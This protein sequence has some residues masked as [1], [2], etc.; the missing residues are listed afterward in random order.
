VREVQGAVK[1]AA[2]EA[3]E[4]RVNCEEVNV[5]QNL[6]LKNVEKKMKKEKKKKK[7]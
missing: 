4:A 2:Q 1:D 5:S 6:L 3:Q 7:F